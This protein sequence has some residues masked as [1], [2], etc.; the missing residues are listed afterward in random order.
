MREKKMYNAD[1]RCEI[2]GGGRAFCELRDHPDIIN[3]HEKIAAAEL[4]TEKPEE[5]EDGEELK[6]A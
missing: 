2:V 3:K 5:N 4:L 6:D 1:E